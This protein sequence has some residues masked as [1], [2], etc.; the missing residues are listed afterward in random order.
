MNI[1]ILDNREIIID[2]SDNFG[3]QN[4]NKASIINFSFPESLINANKKIVFITDDGNFWDLIVNNSYKIT[5]AVTKYKSVSAYVWLVD[6]ENDIDFRSKMWKMTFNKN[7]QPD[8]VVPSEEQI[9]VFDTM[10]SQLN[11]AISEVDNINVDAEKIDNVATI[12]VINKDGTEKSVEI[13]DGEDY[14]I[15]EEDYENIAEI[16]ESHISTDGYTKAETDNLLS[17]KVDKET[18]KSLIENAKIAKLDGIENEAQVNIIETVKVNETELIPE[19]KSINISVPTDLK[20]LNTDTTHRTVT[21]IEKTTWNNKYDK[22]SGG[23]PKTDLSTTVGNSLDKADTSIQEEDLVDYVKNTDYATS[24]TGGV[25]KTSTTYNTGINNGELY[26]ETNT[27]EQYQSKGNNTFIGKGTLENVITGK[28]LET[29]DN[30]VTSID[31]NSTDTQYPTAKLLYQENQE[32]RNQFPESTAEGAEMTLTDSANMKIAEFELEGQ[33]EQEGEPSLDNECPVHVVT[34]DCEVE[35]G[36]KNRWDNNKITNILNG[37]IENGIIT[38]NVSSSAFNLIINNSLKLKNGINYLAFKLKVDS[39]TAGSLNGSA[40]FY[41]TSNGELKYFILSTRPTIIS[42]YQDYLASVEVSEDTEISQIGLTLQG[43]NVIYSLK[44]I[45]VTSSNDTSYIPHAEQTYPLSL[46]NIELCKIGNYQDYIYG[47]TDN[48]YI[49]RVIRDYK[50]TGEE[51]FYGETTMPSGLTRFY[52]NPGKAAIANNN[53]LLAKSNLLLGVKGNQL[54]TSNVDS[55]FASSYYINLILKDITTRAALKTMLQE[56]D[57]HVYY[58]LATPTTTKITDSTLISQL[59]ALYKAKTY[60]N[61]TNI[62]TTGE[63]LQPILKLTYKQDLQMITDTLKSRVSE[64]DEEITELKSK[65]GKTYTIRRKVDNNTSPTWERL[66]DNIG[67]VANATKDG[68][69]VTNDF[70]N[71]SPWKDIISFNLDLTTGKKKTYYGDVDFKFDGTNGDVYTH[72]PTFWLKIWKE[73]GYMYISIADYNKTGYTEI[74]EFD[75]ARY[76]TGIGTDNKLHSYSGI[77]G[78]SDKN[79][80]EYRTLAQALGDDYCLLDWR[81]FAIQ[82]LYLVEYASFYSQSTL[83]KGYVSMRHNNTDVALVAGTNTQYFV[84]NSTAGNAFVVGQQVKIGEWENASAVTR[85]ITAK[86][87]YSSGDITGI[88]LTLDQAVSSITTS[89][90]IW[91]CVQNAG[92]CDSLGMKSGCLANDSKHQVIY[93]GIEG[94]F[95]NIWQFFDGIN[96][97]DRKTWVCYE[98]AEYASNKFES[99]YEELGYTNLASNGNPK[100]L[101][102]DIN[103]PLIQ[104]PTESGGSSTTGTTD[105][106]WQDAGNKVARVG[107]YLTNGDNC[108]LWFWGLNTANSLANWSCGARVLKYK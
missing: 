17:N 100:T 85:T 61:L 28:N 1:T 30:K 86:T 74:K 38:T 91:S 96:I 35:F 41:T 13:N 46:G 49:Q 97:K 106:Y 32:L 52:F 95:G 67:K 93:R 82:C 57:L 64:L 66:D 16:V 22:P 105:H 24:S 42:E 40:A 87:A 48:W 3:T 76:L 26:V 102:F 7:Q 21:D 45:I 31:E 25:I 80:V 65:G 6:E 56:K 98:P 70:D 50:V 37:T 44:D 2:S 107:G 8:D 27:Y 104:F 108:G 11:S 59:N 5:N 72:I 33:T 73:N 90:T 63:D 15:T 51:T 62:T 89:T 83:G 71:L 36:N 20:D 68:G 23:I 55:V 92:Q 101:G 53:I 14:I 75:I 94:I 60:K 77:E 43:K 34:G 29:A 9:N 78:A 12:T 10:I 81:Y 47:S 39:G 18:G 19:N 54:A 88:Q 84:V 79:I 103:H 4:E 99:P 69:T 58:V